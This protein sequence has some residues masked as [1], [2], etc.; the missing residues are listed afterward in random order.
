MKMTDS[1]IQNAAFIATSLAP[2]LPY[3]VEVGKGMAKVI[4]EEVSKE[5]LN[6]AQ[7][8]WE[9][10]KTHFKGDRKIEASAAGLAKDP[11]DQDYLHLMAKALAARMAEKPELAEELVE[12]LGGR[13]AVQKVL[14]DKSSWV[15]QVIQ[16]IK[17]SGAQTVEAT[18]DSVIK[19][20]KQHIE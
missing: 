6:N 5:S 11:T 18:N 3:L 9:K 16:E 8:A 15:E 17:G 7:Q 1:L 2:F 13:Q 12:V 4:G 10:I 20:V 14:A 19:N